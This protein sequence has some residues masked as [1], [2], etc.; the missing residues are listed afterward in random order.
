MTFLTLAAVTANKIEPAYLHQ[1]IMMQPLWLQI[2]VGW[3]G[4]INFGGALA[5][6][7]RAEAKWV[8]AAIIAAAIMMSW[9]YDQIGYQRLL[10]LPHVIFWTPLLIY[11]WR[12]RAQWD[13]SR[14]SGKWLLILF[15]TNL[16]S[17]VIDYID[18]ARYLSGERL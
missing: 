10:G 7:K 9:L 16:T 5:F 4:L 6:I 17:L 13:L 11:L 15:A 14:L 18:V 2:W 8:L 3:M 12:R 1:A